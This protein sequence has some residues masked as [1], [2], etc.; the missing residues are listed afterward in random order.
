MFVRAIAARA[1]IGS[2]LL[3][4]LVLGGAFWL[5][6]GEIERQLTAARSHELLVQGR[7]LCSVVREAWDDAPARKVADLVHE[8]EREDTTVILLRADGIPLIDTT[9]GSELSTGVWERGET[10]TA[11][12]SG[13]S[14]GIAPLG[15]GETD[16]HYL[17]IRVGKSDR[18]LGIVWLSRAA[19]TQA[20][21]WRSLGKLR[22]RVIAIGIAAAI[23]FGILLDVLRKRLVRRLALAARDLSEGDLSTRVELVGGDELAP[24]ALALSHLR[25]RL[26]D[27]VRTID[28]QRATLESLVDQLQEGVIVTRPDGCVALV[29]PSARRLLN[30]TLADGSSEESPEGQAIEKVI[31]QH[32]VQRLLRAEPPDSNALSDGRTSHEARIQVETDEGTLHLLAR[33]GDVVFPNESPEAESPA[34]GRMLVLTD[35]TEL[36]RALRIKTDFVANASH[37]LRTPLSTIRAAAETL[38]VLEP[39]ESV[40]AARRFVEAIDRQSGRLEALVADLLD[41]SRLESVN[42]HQQPKKLHAGEILGDLHTRFAERLTEKR[43]RWVTNCVT[44]STQPVIAPPNALRLVL[45]NLVDNAIKFTDPGGEIQVTIAGGADWVSL[46]VADSGCGIPPEEQDRV[47]ERFY[48][49]E[50]S[51]SGNERG[52]GLGLSIV[53]HAVASM[54]GTVRLESTPGKGTRVI[55]KIPYSE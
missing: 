48:Q 15:P 54:N 17:V 43:I 6:T 33:A 44:G 19:T 13:E 50:R 47:F 10:Q 30:L 52:T 25:D 14:Q 34:V 37:E 40:G 11:L 32:E 29:N 16:S 51:R 23:V 7:M 55:V 26:A 35:I 31:P 12:V 21:A 2:A 27:Q 36:A 42:N 20:E 49:V 39:T 18:P 53:R 45:D 46:E 9:L 22:G 28:H 8:L 3:L 5:I 4:V 38:L 1:L 24:L 41:L